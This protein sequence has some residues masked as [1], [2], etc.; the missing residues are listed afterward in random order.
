VP[1]GD[2][3]REFWAIEIQKKNQETEFPQ[4]NKPSLHFSSIIVLESLI[5]MKRTGKMVKD[6]QTVS[7]FS[8]L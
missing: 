2:V 6:I 5:K 1:S 7:F 3:Y 8:F 4:P